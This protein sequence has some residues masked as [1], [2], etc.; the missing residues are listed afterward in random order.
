M[1]ELRNELR[2]AMQHSRDNIS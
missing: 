2:N 1:H